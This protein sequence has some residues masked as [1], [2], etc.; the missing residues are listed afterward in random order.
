MRSHNR[1]HDLPALYKY[2]PASTAMAILGTQSLRWSSPLRFNFNDPFDIPRE[3][4]GFTYAELEDAFVES[5]AVY[6]RGEAS[7]NSPAARALLQARR[8]QHSPSD[9]AT[10]FDQMRFFLH[11]MR[12]KIENHMEEMRV[13]WR[14]KIPGM[15]ILCFTEDPCSATMW[16][17]YAQAHTGVVLEFETSDERDSAW[18]L[19][20]PVRYQTAKPLLPSPTEWARAFMGEI[21]LNWDRF[22]AE[23]HFV[24]HSDWSYEREH[25]VVSARKPAETGLFGD[26]VFHREDLRAIILGANITSEDTAAL[27]AAVAAN[28]PSTSVYRAQIDL[29]KRSIVRIAT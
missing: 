13:A 5:F 18:L 3:W 4:D 25:R 19:A 23:Y 10:F 6:L 14:E 1:C 22:L 11:V 24:K 20:E 17:H 26:Y 28:Y 9:E 27:R 29:A 21:D 16:A 15:R 8:A 2:C 7:P 12:P